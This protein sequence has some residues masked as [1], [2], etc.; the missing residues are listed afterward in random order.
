MDRA[1]N[2]AYTNWFLGFRWPI[3]RISKQKTLGV[4][5]NGYSMSSRVKIS[6]KDYSLVICDTAIENT[7][8]I[9]DLPIQNGE[10]SIADC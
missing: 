1:Y 2:A 9:I 7:P 4:I 3:H 5:S 6:K 10:F 8:F